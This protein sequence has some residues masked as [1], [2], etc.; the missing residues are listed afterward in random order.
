MRSASGRHHGQRGAGDLYLW[1]PS[2]LDYI[3]DRADVIAAPR[4]HPMVVINLSYGMMADP[5]DGTGE[6]ENLIDDK[7]EQVETTSASTFTS[8][9]RPA[10]AASRAAMHSS[11]SPRSADAGACNGASCPTIGRRAFSRSGCPLPVLTR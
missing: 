11:R 7:I 9:Y 5:H 6:I 4:R 1:D 10:T 8:S 2:A 3:L